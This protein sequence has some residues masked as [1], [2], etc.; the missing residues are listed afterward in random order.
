[1]EMFGASDLM[2]SFVYY[3]EENTVVKETDLYLIHTTMKK[4]STWGKALLSLFVL[5][6]AGAV[7]QET[8]TTK[9]VK[10]TRMDFP[11]KAVTEYVF[12]GGKAVVKGKLSG[13]KEGELPKTLKLRIVNA[14]TQQNVNSTIEVNSNGEFVSEVELPYAQF[15]YMPP[16]HFFLFPG[17]TLECAFNAATE[18]QTYFGENRSAQ[19]S[20]QYPQWRERYLGKNV[21]ACRVPLRNLA[22]VM[23]YRDKQIAV[24]D[25]LERDVRNR[26]LPSSPEDLLVRDIFISSIFT[27]AFI[28]TM[29]G[30]MDYN[31]FGD[32]KSEPLIDSLYYNFLP[33]REY[34]LL[35]TPL[36]LFEPSTWVLANRMEYGL[37][38][39]YNKI[40]RNKFKTSFFSDDPQ[41]V[42]NYKSNFLLPETFS[43]PFYQTALA[44]RRKTLHTLS[45]HYTAVREAMSRELHLDNS[46]LFQLYL[47]RQ[48]FDD[49]RLYAEEAPLTP[50][51]AMEIL[52]SVIPELTH[53]V[54]CHHFLKGYRKFVVENEAKTPGHSA[55]T[56]ADSI[57]RRITAPYSGN[58]LVLDFWDYSCGP[59][60]A[61]MMGQRELVKAMKGRPVK[62]L[63]ICDKR[64]TSRELANKFL[65]P[66]NIGGEH[67]FISHDEWN[68]L[69]VKFNFSGIPFM[70]LI[71]REGKDHPLNANLLNKETLEKFM[72]P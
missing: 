48:V 39:R 5:S 67:I 20:R 34:F 14:V 12:R 49:L 22:N 45:Q 21:S 24:M 46:F 30:Y 47:S 3:G 51:V 9:E 52:A 62:F 57:L 31:R 40:C 72:Q 53:P 2:Y 42:K 54:I 6:P 10:A 18:Q 25:S 11:S 68:H 23:A 59:C 13:F 33:Q 36:L 43:E 4:L 50:S 63:Y 55:T 26:S 56:V 29:E 61:G 60:R 17:D 28:N 27:E 66:N 1:M 70:R 64:S 38:Q 7:A 41:E 35:D 65:K 44:Y 37:Y 32:T 19:V 58:V 71:D 15:I 69:S 8:V 16:F